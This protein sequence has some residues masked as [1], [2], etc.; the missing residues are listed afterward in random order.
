M[1]TDLLARQI[2][3]RASHSA[4]GDAACSAHDPG[5]PTTGLPVEESNVCKDLEEHLHSIVSG[6]ADQA[7]KKK[8]V[9]QDISRMVPH[10]VQGGQPSAE[11]PASESTP[12]TLGAGHRARLF[13]ILVA[14]AILAQLEKDGVYH[15]ADGVASLQIPLSNILD[16]PFAPLFRRIAIM[17]DNFFRQL[18][19]AFASIELF[20]VDRSIGGPLSPG[21]LQTPKWTPEH[22]RELILGASAEQIQ[23]AA[24]D[25]ATYSH[26]GHWRTEKDLQKLLTGIYYA[27]TTADRT[28]RP[29]TSKLDA[30]LEE[31]IKPFV[32]IV[33][34]ARSHHL[35]SNTS[36]E[37]VQPRTN[38]HRLLH[39]IA[40]TFMVCCSL[41][42]L[43]HSNKTRRDLRCFGGPT[44]DQ[45]A[46]F[47]VEQFDPSTAEGHPCGESH[48][49]CNKA[50]R[51]VQQDRSRRGATLGVTSN[52]SVHTEGAVRGVFAMV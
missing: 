2:S 45:H 49:R 18:S 6:A 43:P 24:A 31:I 36:T 4:P 8:R 52:H 41:P 9:S 48:S 12:L 34:C 30:E 27:L 25:P 38:Q 28:G 26:S 16:P 22:L 51:S 10:S 7:T 11:Q 37:R 39:Q 20:T 1:E 23:E 15:S 40:P 33:L 21:V 3:A 32:S 50:R 17:A 5:V 44:E 46:H 14:E 29:S 35:L 13:L 42:L 19:L 47:A